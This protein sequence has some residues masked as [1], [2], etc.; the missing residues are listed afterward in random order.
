M[1]HLSRDIARWDR[2]CVVYGV[3]SMYNGLKGVQMLCL[4][5]AF[6]TSLSP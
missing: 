1:S 5:M 6:V 3:V 2:Y 4:S